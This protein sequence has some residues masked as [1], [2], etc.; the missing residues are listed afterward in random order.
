MKT[1]IKNLF[2]R[3]GGASCA[4]WVLPA[5]IAGLGLIPAGRVTAQTFTTLY[6]FTGDSDGGN[7][8]AGL[9]LSGNTLYGTA[10]YG[11]SSGAGTVFAVNT[12]G[13][14][15][16]NL[17]S[18]TGGSDGAYPQAGLV[19]SGNTLYGAA[20]Q[21]GILGHGTVFRLNTDGTGFTNLY[22]F[23][24]FS[25][26]TNS[27]GAN[28]HAGLILS[29]NTL[30]GTARNGGSFN[31]GTVFA[32]NTD[33][34]GFTILHTFTAGYYNSSY[35]IL[36]SDGASPEA[37]LILSGNTLYGT[38]S[39]D[40]SSGYGTVFAVN[41]NGTGFTILHSFTAVFGPNYTNSDGAIP[42]GGLILS[43]NTLYGTAE[44]GG[45][46][47]NGTVFAVNTNGTG[48][49][50][51]YSFTAASSYPFF[52]NSDGAVPYGGLILSDNTLYGTAYYGGNS[53]NGTVFGVN[54]DGTGFTNLHSFTAL[55]NNNA[56][57]D[58]ANP[59]AGLILSGN[60]LYG[61]ALQGGSVNNGTVFSL[62]FA[63]QL[64]IIS[65][66]GNVILT[67]PTNVAG[68]SYAGFTLQSATNLVSPIVWSTVSPGPTVVNGQN[69]VT[70]AVSGTQNFYRLSQ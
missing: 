50:T 61:T 11:G 5:L 32:V 31:N 55:D 60:T 49:T 18:F 47:G 19:L 46:S 14:G 65:S 38:A 53:G 3:L 40:G 34:T 23:S 4:A 20:S 63:P 52:I 30:Y 54:T 21:G 62:S 36:N 6:S 17:Y 58:G 41:T 67:W 12:D 51:L 26:Y 8:Y 27:D 16:T 2:T 68:F 39:L 44:G 22:N 9:I 43:G 42:Y 66:G 37:G 25:N 10:L 57:S 29:G 48:F 69:A 33:G 70:N 28:P 56:N 64:T 35:V 24:A 45:S 15:F 7:P 59:Y 13:T 1:H